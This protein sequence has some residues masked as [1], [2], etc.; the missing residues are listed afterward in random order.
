MVNSVGRV[1]DYLSSP[2]S[3]IFNFHSDWWFYT[4]PYWSQSRKEPN[5][6]SRIAFR[7]AMKYT[8]HFWNNSGTLPEGCWFDSAGMDVEVSLGK[9]LNPKLLLMSWLAVRVRMYVWITVRHFGQKCLLNALKCKYHW[10]NG[11]CSLEVPPLLISCS[12]P[13]PCL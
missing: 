3:F 7:N 9:T 8:R 5:M 13:K 12:L 11:S 6:F 2:V 4:D 10:C 1:N